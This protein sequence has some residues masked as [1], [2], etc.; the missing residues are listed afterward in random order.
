MP[1]KYQDLR[2]SD[3]LFVSSPKSFL[4]PIYL[5]GINSPLLSLKEDKSFV[6]LRT[7]IT[8]AAPSHTAYL[9]HIPR[10]T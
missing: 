2:T 9:A 8:E 7:L 4:G 1:L 10:T 6:Q 5:P 3:H